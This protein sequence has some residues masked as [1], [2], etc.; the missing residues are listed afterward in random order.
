MTRRI[1]TDDDYFLAGRSLGPGLVTLSV[2][3]TWFGAETCIGASGAIY[4]GGLYSSR[5]DPFGYTMCL[6]LMAFVLAVPLWRRRMTTLADLFRNHYRSAVVEKLAILVL[7]PISLVWAAAQ[8]KAFGHVLSQ[9]SDLPVEW[10][11]GLAAGTVIIYT[12]WGGLLGDVVTDLIQGLVLIVGLFILLGVGLMACQQQGISFRDIEPARLSLVAPGVSFWSR[13]DMWMIPILGSLVTQELFQKVVAAR[14]PQVAKKSCLLGAGLYLV[15]GLIPVVFGL[16]GPHLMPNVDHPDDFLIT[17]AHGLLPNFL[18]VV[19]AGALVS[20]ILSTVDSTLLAISAFA[21]HNLMGR[22]FYNRPEA[23]RLL[24][25]RT[26]VLVAGLVALLVALR[27][28]GVYDL[29][30]EASSIG[31]AGL[32]VVMIMCLHFP[33][34]GGAIAASTTLIVGAVALPLF[35]AQSWIGAPYLAA[36]GLSL[37]VYLLCA[38]TLDRWRERT[39]SSQKILAEGEAP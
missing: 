38:V 36:I 25:A 9:V 17:F 32:L 3:A 18:Y 13:L 27:G 19:F 29:V 34:V 8:V 31:T 4:S 12:F 28:K 14:S 22:A 1:K 5:A 35:Q 30:L 33:K 7:L 20:A 23:L 6:L 11:M 21:T 37:T 2:F 16:L 39:L 10:G 15:V 24:I 26:T